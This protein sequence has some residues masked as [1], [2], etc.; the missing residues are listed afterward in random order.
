MTDR[1]KLLLKTYEIR[2][3]IKELKGEELFDIE[4]FAGSWTFRSDA[5]NETIASLQQKIENLT[6]ELEAAKKA[7][8]LKDRI[9][10]YL[11]T[12][13]GKQRMATLEEQ[14][15]L[16]LAVFR[17]YRDESFARLNRFAKE[18][19]GDGWALESLCDNFV[20][21][22]IEDPQRRNGRDF[23][24]GQSVE[25]YFEQHSFFDSEKERFEMSIG[26]TGC[27]DIQATEYGDRSRF[28]I[29]V[30]KFLG[31]EVAVQQLKEMLF[32]YE[33][34]MNGI[35]ARVRKLNEQIK[36]PLAA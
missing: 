1:E 9:D 25:V 33:E 2:N 21:F 20:K 24:F 32:L 6:R 27:F 22:S 36:N 31:N 16:E 11:S 5:K 14:K 29:E 26:S 18:V 13:E 28:Y 17:N 4:S 10:A 23:V 8:A 30:G 19:I 3:Q 34:N 15:A 7:K 12:E 35:K